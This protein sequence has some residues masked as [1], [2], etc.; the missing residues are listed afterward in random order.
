MCALRSLVSIL[1]WVCL[2]ND[3]NELTA[4]R[5]EDVSLSLSS[6]AQFHGNKVFCVVSTDRTCVQGAHSPRASREST[7]ANAAVNTG[8]S[9]MEL[10]NSN[11]NFHQ[12]VV[13]AFTV[14]FSIF[15]KQH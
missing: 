10:I 9:N 13:D 1:N 12:I 6:C 14:P 3:F 2:L 15:A 4:A 5:K 7:Q 8:Q 11:K